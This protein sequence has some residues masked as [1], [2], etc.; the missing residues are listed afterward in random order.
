MSGALDIDIKWRTFLLISFQRFFFWICSSILESQFDGKYN[1]FFSLSPHT[2]VAGELWALKNFSFIGPSLLFHWE[3]RSCTEFIS[4][5]LKILWNLCVNFIW[6][7]RKSFMYEAAGTTFAQKIARKMLMK[8]TPG[9]NKVTKPSTNIIKS[10][11]FTKNHKHELYL[12]IGNE[13]SLQNKFSETRRFLWLVIKSG[14]CKNVW[15]IL[16][17]FNKFI[18]VCKAV[19]SLH[20]L[21]RFIPHCRILLLFCCFV[22]I[23]YSKAFLRSLIISFS[24]QYSISPTFYAQIYCTKVLFAALL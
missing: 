11:F 5:F 20:T 8:L 12:Q 7:L 24:F 22:M 17:F 10:T 9:V 23:Y 2:F 18:F 13:N 21:F 3:K 15:D 16:F 6:D 19:S 14:M 1:I 4:K